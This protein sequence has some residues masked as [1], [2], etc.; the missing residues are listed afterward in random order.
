MKN[1]RAQKEIILDEHSSNSIYSFWI[2]RERFTPFW[3]FHPEVELTLITK[4][5]GVRIVGDSIQPFHETDLVL[6]GSNLPHNWISFD[7]VSECEAFVLQFSAKVLQS[8]G[9]LT[10]ID[11]FVRTST[12]GISFSNPDEQLLDKIRSFN[13]LPDALKY[14]RL[15]EILFE[16]K[17]EEPTE[18]LTSSSYR[19]PT[20]NYKSQQRYE[21][22]TDFVI[23]NIHRKITLEEAAGV[24]NMSRES[25]SR[26]FKDASGTSFVHYLNRTRTE[27]ACHLLIHSDDPINEVAYKVGFESL[28]QF[29]R[30]FKNYKNTS[31]LK[32]RKRALFRD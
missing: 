12:R 2:Q 20:Y 25:F 10:S 30:C 6:L 26:W 15:I 13:D 22:V 21:N 19:I 5:K 1:Y 8:A 7:T 31:P 9:E 27:I 3:H 16:L 14:A 28:S 32:F 11:E 23:N 17:G 24:G 29:H 4:G 18:F